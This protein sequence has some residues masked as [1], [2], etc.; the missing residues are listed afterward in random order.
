M[1]CRA[2]TRCSWPEQLNFI[3]PPSP[4]SQN[5]LHRPVRSHWHWHWTHTTPPPPPPRH[6]HPRGTSPGPPD[7]L[8][9][10][11]STCTVLGCQLAWRQQL[12]DYGQ[13]HR[14]PCGRQESVDDSG[15]RYRKYLPGF[16]RLGGHSDR[17]AR[18]LAPHLISQPF[19]CT[20]PCRT[21][22]IGHYGTIGF[23]MDSGPAVNIS[24]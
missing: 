24:N 12:D 15:R 20:L 9:S 19:I 23:W 11:I 3:L 4:T 22:S 16:Q 7:G 21:V 14:A 1:H 18:Y 8:A 13:K 5:S 10:C 17:L 2:S 6:R